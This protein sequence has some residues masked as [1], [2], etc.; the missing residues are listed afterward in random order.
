MV[1]PKPVGTCT[2]YMLPLKFL[3]SFQFTML[4]FF[5]PPAPSGFS[6]SFPSIPRKA[7]A[8]DN[9]CETLLASAAK[10]HRCF[11]QESPGLDLL[12]G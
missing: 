8:L 5:T 1:A 9:P 7:G 3:L 6:L 11:S 10:M 12:S 2:R 4:G